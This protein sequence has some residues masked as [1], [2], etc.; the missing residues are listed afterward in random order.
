[1]ASN[2]WTNGTN[3]RILGKMRQNKSGIINLLPL[4]LIGVLVTGGIGAA[5]YFGKNSNKSIISKAT[6]TPEAMTEE[7]TKVTG[8]ESDEMVPMKTYE[9]EGFSFKYPSD[10]YLIKPPQGSRGVISISNYDPEEDLMPESGNTKLEISNTMSNMTPKE[11]T[12]STN[13]RFEEYK[14]NSFV[15]NPRLDTSSNKLGS[16]IPTIAIFGTNTVTDSEFVEYFFQVSAEEV[17]SVTIYG[18]MENQ[19]IVDQILSTFEFTP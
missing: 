14:T 2:K 12:D 5:Y 9:G 17:F 8:E 18:A 10:W 19:G 7:E 6:S 13:Q 3:G 1:M 11:L 4:I 15:S 16:N